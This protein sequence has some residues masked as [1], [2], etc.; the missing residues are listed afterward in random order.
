MVPELEERSSLIAEIC[1]RYDVERLEVFGSASRGDSAFNDV[2]LIVRFAHPGQPGYADRYF[3]LAEALEQAL[4]RRVDLL[5][6]RS[7]RNPVF[8][9][10]VNRD[11]RTIYAAA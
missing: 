10:M 1:R 8:V 9:E 2:D 11:R 6:E 3:E 4:G 7:L 5:T